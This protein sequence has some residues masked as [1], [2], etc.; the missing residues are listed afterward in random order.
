MI[1]SQC[2]SNHNTYKKS[3]KGEYDINFYYRYFWYD[4]LHPTYPVHQVLAK[5]IIAYLKEN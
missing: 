3:G 1:A 4:N 2:K 5:D